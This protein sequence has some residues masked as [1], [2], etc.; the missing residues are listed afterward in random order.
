MEN[1]L[2]YSAI[3]RIKLLCALRHHPAALAMDRATAPG[4]ELPS[5]RQPITSAF[6]S[7]IILSLFLVLAIEHVELAIEATWLI[8]MG[9]QHDYQSMKLRGK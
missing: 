2:R 1:I 3:Q 8:L 6:A 5:C 9:D 4:A 7:D